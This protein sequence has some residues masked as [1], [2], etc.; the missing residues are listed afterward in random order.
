MTV[1]PP[2]GADRDRGR[3]SGPALRAFLRIA[4]LW[5]L[6][7]DQQMILLGVTARSTLFKWKKSGSALPKDT[8]ERISRILGIYE[9]LDDRGLRESSGPRQFG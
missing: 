4:D 5:G 1:Q 2:G 9:A 7:V 8:L 6:P 3:L